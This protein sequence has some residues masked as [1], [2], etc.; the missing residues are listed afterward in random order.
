MLTSKSPFRA[1]AV[2]RNASLFTHSMVSPTLAETS[3]G[4][5][6]RFSMTIWIV[7]ACAGTAIAASASAS[8][9]CR[10]D[11][12]ASSLLQFCRDHLGML[13]MALEDFQAGLQQALQLGIVGRR[14]QLRFQRAVDRLVV[15]DLVG[16]IGLVVFGA[17]QLL[18][19]GELVGR[20]L[21]QRLAGV[22]VF[23]RDFQLLDEVERLLVHGFVVAHH[24]LREGLHLLV[25][26]LGERLLGGVDVD[27]AGGVGDMGDLR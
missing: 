18:E 7:A 5:T 2:W 26:G 15:G 27:H 25:A 12:M 13:L 8:T 23:G 17:F 1:V 6:T 10:P 24:V 16:D 11:N 22:V 14:D 4:A 9:I 21:R 19:L 3:N 20:V